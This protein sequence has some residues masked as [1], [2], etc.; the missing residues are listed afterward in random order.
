MARAAKFL[1]RKTAAQWAAANP[2]LGLGTFGIELTTNQLKI[3]DGVTDW[4]G[5]HYAASPYDLSLGP[6]ARTEQHPAEVWRLANP[7]LGDQIIGYESDTH[8]GKIGDGTTPW[9]SLAYINGREPVG[10]LLLE[11]GAALLLEDGS[12]LLLAGGTVGGDSPYVFTTR[13]EILGGGGAS[14]LAA[15]TTSIQIT[16]GA[17]AGLL[18]TTRIAVQ[19]GARASLLNTTNIAILGGGAAGLT[20]A[21]PYPMAD[22]LADAVGVNVHLEYGGSVYDTGY[23]T[24]VRPRLNELGTRHIRSGIG[25]GTARTN[26]I[27]RYQQLAAQGIKLLLINTSYVADVTYAAAHLDY[28]EALENRN[29]PDVFD[30]T[31]ADAWKPG[32]RARH[33]TFWNAVRANS[34]L[35]GVPVLPSPLG[36]ANNL[37]WW[38]SNFADVGSY[39][40][41]GSVHDYTNDAA[42]KNIPEQL[43][44]NQGGGWIGFGQYYTNSQVEAKL[45]TDLGSTKDIY[46]TEI[47]P[48]YDGA[49]ALTEHQAAKAVARHLLTRVLAHGRRRLYFY[50]L[51]ENSG[52]EDFG[53]LTKA[54]TPRQAFHALRNLISLFRDPGPAFQTTTLGYTLSTATP[55]DAELPT[56]TTFV[57]AANYAELVSC[58]DAATAGTCITLTS[59]GASAYAGANLSKTLNGTGANPIVIRGPATGTACGVRADCPKI[60]FDLVIDGRDVYFYGLD[61]N[62][63]TSDLTNSTTLRLANTSKY[64]TIRRCWGYRKFGNLIRLNGTRH[65]VDY[66]DLSVW[67]V[68]EYPTTDGLTPAPDSTKANWLPSGPFQVIYDGGSVAT[69]MTVRRNYVH[70]CPF[71]MPDNYSWHVVTGVSNG[72]NP[73]EAQEDAYW[74]VKE[75]LV[76][77]AGHM[78][79]ATKTSR[80][81]IQGNTIDGSGN[82]TNFNQRAGNYN[83][84]LSN[85][86]ETGTY[87]PAFS[88]HGGFNKWIGNRLPSGKTFVTQCGDHVWSYQYLSSDPS[89]REHNSHRA[90]YWGN[91]GAIQDGYRDDSAKTVVPT[92]T[93]IVPTTGQ[94]YTNIRATGPS[95]TAPPPTGYT[96]VP[97]VKLT[98]AVV[99]PGAA[100]IVP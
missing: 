98:A 40:D 39:C 74:L 23:A 72:D 83:D 11:T 3:G 60:P 54:G 71:K 82:K 31:P 44:A 1:V 55:V 58:L 22:L 70:D 5:L 63:G 89:D 91:L 2:I 47:G 34:A 24:I 53:L 41:V 13:I 14:L 92:E 88:G 87:S 45:R 77:Q 7:V 38:H 81:T 20:G 8:R 57:T 4:A 85:W 79:I 68:Q 59:T 46:S 99:G 19:G 86:Y 84:Y 69:Y 29:E 75:N 93:Q 16:G 10:I 95:L 66:C 25:S 42:G 78:D 33:V 27:T 65:T 94:T 67:G 52:A 17:G 36:H 43:T 9:R 49:A 62:R 48:R 96:L 73:I 51:I 32:L 61:F 30:N 80:N 18:A 21:G 90:L 26:A 64:I 56:S 15:R 100:W 50:Q 35:N 28:V 37:D 6:T 12:L 97:A 76:W